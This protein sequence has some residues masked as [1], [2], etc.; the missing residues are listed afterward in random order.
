MCGI[1]GV[2]GSLR[3]R[4]DALD[5]LLPAL[6][7]RG[8]DD[9]GRYADDFAALGQR[10]LSIIDLATGHQPLRNAEGTLWLIAN[11]EI[12]NYRELREDLQNRGHRFLTNSDCE[13]ILHLYREYGTKCLDHLRG[14]YA[15]ALWDT[16]K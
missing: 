8:P 3:G 14:M 1:A 16:E 5:R 12:Y 6:A 10:R 15:F 7:H 11:G 2:V 4:P 13:V 9:E